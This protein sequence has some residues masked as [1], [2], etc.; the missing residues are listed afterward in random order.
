MRDYSAA[1]GVE[2]KKGGCIQKGKGRGGKGK[3]RMMRRGVRVCLFVRV[4]KGEEAGIRR[5]G[6]EL[7]E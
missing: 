4:E 3:G 6:G 2:W 7:S 1:G 5:G